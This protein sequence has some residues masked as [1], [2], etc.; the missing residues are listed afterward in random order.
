M[1]FTPYSVIPAQ[2]GIQAFLAMY[3][4]PVFTGMTNEQLA[5]ISSEFFLLSGFWHSRSF[6]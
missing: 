4:I 5:G 6:A 2:A 1:V 3:W